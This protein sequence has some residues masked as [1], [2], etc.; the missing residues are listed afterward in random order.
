MKKPALR[1]IMVLS[2]FAILALTAYLIFTG[3]RNTDLSKIKINV[4][5]EDS[6]ITL[7]GS[8]IKERTLDVQPGEHSIEASKEG[9]KPHKL[10]FETAKGA[11]KEI[12]L[13]PEPTSEEALE[14]LRA[15]PDIQ[16]RRESFASQNVTEQQAIFENEYPILTVLPYISAD[17]RVDYGV[18]KK[19][20]DNPNKI[21]LY[22][23][24]IS[25]ELR[26]MAVNWIMSQGYNPAEYEIVF[27]NFDN[28]FIEND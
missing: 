11:T 10:D 23:T 16:L 1:M 9:F 2:L 12:Y 15:N 4:I 7:D 20:P 27:V 26:K 22:I 19:Y 13:L 25:P 18:S 24:A 6:T 28:P 21:A 14:W 5:P 3:N 17:F 8:V